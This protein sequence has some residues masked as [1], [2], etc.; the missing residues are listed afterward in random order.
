MNELILDQMKCLYNTHAQIKKFVHHYA[1]LGDLKPPSHSIWLKN[2]FSPR[3]MRWRK[4]SVSVSFQFCFCISASHSD[5]NSSDTLVLAVSLNLNLLWYE[6][7]ILTGQIMDLEKIGQIH[8]AT[9]FQ[10][11]TL[12]FAHFL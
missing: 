5:W 6:T 10:S 11:S 1:L 3:K 2:L 9:L 8:L 7:S 12:L 4:S